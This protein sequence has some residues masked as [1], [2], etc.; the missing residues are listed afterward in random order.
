MK[1]TTV[2]SFFVLIISASL[3]AGIQLLPPLTA[4]GG[5]PVI[6]L[7]ARPPSARVNEM[8]Y[9]KANLPGIDCGCFAHHA[10]TVLNEP[11]ATVIGTSYKNRWDLA[12][13]QGIESCS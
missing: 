11:R 13:F 1:S 9:C 8:A 5:L 10:G 4:P 12:R 2:A 7:A 3:V 6:N